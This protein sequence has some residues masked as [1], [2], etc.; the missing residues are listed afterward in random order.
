MRWKGRERLGLLLLALVV[1]GGWAGG[2]RAGLWQGLEAESL[3]LRYA[4]R[5]ERPGPLPLVY[6][7]V[8]ER[9]TSLLGERP[10]NRLLFAD[11]ARLLVENG[12]A[13][14]VGFDLLFSPLAHSRLVDP[15]RVREADDGLAEVLRRYP[16]RIVLGANFTGA[17]LPYAAMPSLYRPE[18]PDESTYPEMPTY[19]L[20]DFDYEFGEFGEGDFTRGRVGLLAVLRGGAEGGLLRW[21]PGWARYEGPDHARNI[22]YGVCRHEGLSFEQGVVSTPDGL[23]LRDRTG[24]AR[25]LLPAESTLT[26]YPL[27]LEMLLVH[28]GWPRAGVRVEADALEIGSL[29]P[30][31][32]QPLRR[33]PFTRGDLLEIDWHAR[34]DSPHNRRI[35]LAEVLAQGFR[36]QDGTP[37]EQAAARLFFGSLQGTVV[38]IGP[39][40]P[41]LQDRAPTPLD[42]DPVPRMSAHGNLL[43]ALAEGRVLH[44]PPSWAAFALVLAFTTVS[45]AGFLGPRRWQVFGVAVVAAYAV[46]VFVAFAQGGGVWPVVAPLGAG[47]TML[48]L[49]SLYRLALEQ[50]ARVRLTELFGTYVSP[51]LVERLVERGEEPR[52]GGEERYLTVLFSDVEEF[53]ALA[54][55]LS[56]ERLVPLMNTYLTAM[57]DT[58]QLEGGTLDKYLGDGILALF[59][60]PVELPRAELCACLAAGRMLERQRALCGEWAGQGGWPEGVAA[61]TTHVGIHAGPMVVGNMGSRSRFDYTVM[62]DAVNLAARLQAAAAFYGA[63]AVASAPLRASTEQQ[64]P[65]LVV[66]RRLDLVRV[67]G[68]SQPVELHELL[69]PGRYEPSRACEQAEA[70]AAALTLYESGDLNAAA[71][72]FEECALREDSLGT[73]GSPPAVMAARCR[74]F[75]REGLPVGWDGVFALEAK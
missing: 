65:G 45:A 6:V 66:F 36:L 39:S 54:E 1:M 49:G 67:P 51:G 48:L 17:K 8:D 74:R 57:T 16:D 52:L 63:G 30:G 75:V 19:P 37:A 32:Q 70:Y 47:L 15:E 38:L 20:I 9:A 34:W 60:A 73:A 3:R 10:W 55:H 25:R 24:R 27:A 18:A 23:E 35:S 11:A 43:Q 31:A 26:F 61:M 22:F 5:G 68:R 44:H 71:R 28:K 50:R 56:P 46:F 14:V 69:A 21:V 62:G 72:A 12:G 13:S 7:T 4:L 2:E 29:D 33:I 59:G 64:G 41:L 42:R 58:L 53:S 40:D